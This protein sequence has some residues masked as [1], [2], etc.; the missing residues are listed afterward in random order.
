MAQDEATP[1][2]EFFAGYQWLHPGATVPSPFSPPTAPVGQ[3]MGDIPQGAG[4]SFT[5]NFTPLSWD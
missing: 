5:Y 1:K 2:E 3:K 4:A